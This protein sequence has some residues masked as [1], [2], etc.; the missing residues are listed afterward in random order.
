M[1]PAV[2]VVIGTA[3]TAVVAAFADSSLTP[4]IGLTG[5]AGWAARWWSTASGPPTARVRQPGGHVRADRGGRAL[6]R[7]AADDPAR[8]APPAGR[9]GRDRG[10]PSR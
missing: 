7:G 2:A 9:G 1:E 3:S 10:T 8:R 4:L 5:A 6:P